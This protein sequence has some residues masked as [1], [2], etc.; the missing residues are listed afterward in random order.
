MESLDDG[1]DKI[2][3]LPSTE[4]DAAQDGDAQTPMEAEDSNILEEQWDAIRSVIHFLLEFREDEYC[5]SVQSA[6]KI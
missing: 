5:F 1:E 4:N 2:E 3:V 6:S